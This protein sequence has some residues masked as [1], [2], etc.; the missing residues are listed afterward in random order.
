MTASTTVKL[1]RLIQQNIWDIEGCVKSIGRITSDI[2]RSHRD[3]EANVEALAA[4]HG[5]SW[6]AA[7]F[8]KGKAEKLV[9]E[10]ATL[11]R[12]HE[13]KKKLEWLDK[14]GVDKDE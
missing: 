8:L 6:M 12:L 11:R 9:E 4:N 10:Y 14:L 7:E 2:A 1:D 5:V 3:C 13:E